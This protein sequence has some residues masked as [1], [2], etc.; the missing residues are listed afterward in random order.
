MVQRS[1]FGSIFHLTICHS[2][3]AFELECP[4]YDPL[5]SNLKW[6]QSKKYEFDIN[7]AMVT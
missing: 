5:K 3:I 7:F 6:C 1:G 2:E 4:I